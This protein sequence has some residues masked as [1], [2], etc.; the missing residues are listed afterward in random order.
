M[1]QAGLSIREIGEY[2]SLRHDTYIRPAFLKTPSG[3]CSI[4]GIPNKQ[5]ILLT[6]PGIQRS[7]TAT[8]GSV[9]I[10]GGNTCG[11]LEKRLK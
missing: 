9:D 3:A 5:V 4:R 10:S 8:G 6:P 1:L 2:R 7:D 11:L